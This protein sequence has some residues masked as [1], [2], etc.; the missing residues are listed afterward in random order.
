PIAISFAYDRPVHSPIHHSVFPANPT[1]DAV[2]SADS[3]NSR[4]HLLPSRMCL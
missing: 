4:A 1:S 2:D 3:I